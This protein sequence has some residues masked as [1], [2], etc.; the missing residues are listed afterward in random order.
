MTL[1][2]G[3]RTQAIETVVRRHAA[4]YPPRAA[5]G[6]ILRLGGSVAVAGPLP[7]I[8]R[9]GG[10]AA[11]PQAIGVSIGSDA[12][13]AMVAAVLLWRPDITAVRTCM[14]KKMR[15]AMVVKTMTTQATVRAT[16]AVASVAD[17][18]RPEASEVIAIVKDAVRSCC[19]A[20]ARQGQA[21]TV[22]KVQARRPASRTVQYRPTVACSTAI[23]QMTRD[24][25]SVG[26]GRGEQNHRWTSWINVLV[27]LSLAWKVL[28]P[29]TA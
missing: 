13:I 23:H 12:L 11:D 2:R 6:T 9:G 8:E 3:G 22:P 20:L 25:V 26:H 14:P 24:H 19:E 5:A 18:S 7:M 27:A 21:L 29:A 1:R 28:P 17:I 16:V 15:L 4:R 10:P